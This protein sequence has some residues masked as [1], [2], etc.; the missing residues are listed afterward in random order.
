[1]RAL[2]RYK[3]PDGHLSLIVIKGSS[4]ELAI[5]FEDGSWHT[6][7]DLLSYWLGVPEEKAI[8]YFINLV[9]SNT[10]PIIMSTDKGQTINPWIS[11]SL[12]ET[13]KFYGPENCILRYWD[14]EKPVDLETI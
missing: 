3:S 6:H 2:E 1:M 11:D 5:G 12:K 9:F 8:H 14:V 7:S 4:D 10:L 13:I